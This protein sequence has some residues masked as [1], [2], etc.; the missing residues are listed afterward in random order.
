MMLDY[1]SAGLP[2]WALAAAI[3]VAFFAGLIKGALG[4]ALPMILISGLSSFM[5]V[6][7]ALAGLMLPTLFTNL[8]QALRQGLAAAWGSTRRYWRM[9]SVMVA[10]LLLSAQFLSALPDRALLVLLG[11]PIVLFALVQLAGVPL[12]LNVHRRRRAEWTS[13]A[14]AGLYGGISG[15]W[16]PPVMVYLI[17]VDTDKYDMVRVLGVVFLVGAVALIGGHLVSGV[18]NAQTLGFSALLIAPAMVGLWLGYV[19]QDR[20]DAAQFRR[21][22]LIMLVLTGLNLLRQAFM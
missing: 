21:W 22:T 5:P 6:E 10:L 12:R 14:V 2:L 8:S 18:A 7:L 16:G 17:S 13:G 19:V 20:L 11:G 9:L 15:I 3:G 1:I 4:F